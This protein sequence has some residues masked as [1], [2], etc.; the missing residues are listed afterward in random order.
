MSD[1]EKT[2]VGAIDKLEFEE[3]EE[4]KKM[5]SIT[6]D[7]ANASYNRGLAYWFSLTK[8]LT[9]PPLF[10]LHCPT[11]RGIFLQALNVFIIVL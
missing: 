1:Y 6:S 8:I 7:M 10:P 3:E 4:K 5:A 11:L 9:T 2:V